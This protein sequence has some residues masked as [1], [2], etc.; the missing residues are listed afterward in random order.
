MAEPKNYP[1]LGRVFPAYRSTPIGRK[2]IE[3]LAKYREVRMITEDQSAIIMEEFDKCIHSRLKDLPRTE[4]FT[5][6]QSKTVDFR[7]IFNYYQVIFTPAIIH[8]R[9]QAV[10]CPGLEV[11]AVKGKPKQTEDSSKSRR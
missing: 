10:T 5:C 9:D 6:E 11:M 2:L 7:Y 8:F 3:I 4:N 1:G